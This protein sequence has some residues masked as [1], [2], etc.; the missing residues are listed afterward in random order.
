MAI[1]D[2]PSDYFNTVTYTGTNSDQSITGVNFQ[3]D[4]VWIKS[5]NTTYSHRLVDVV[6]GRTEV[7]FSNNTDATQTDSYGTIGSFDSD[8]VSFVQGT[9]NPSYA[10]TND[11]YNYVMWN[12]L[13]NGTPSSNT[14][15]SITSSV[16]ANTT[17][18]FSII[19]YTGT[20]SVATIGHG[21]GAVPKM[22]ITR[23][24]ST[25]GQWYTYHAS[26]G[27]THY[28]DL[29]STAAAGDDAEMWNDTSPT[30]SVFTVGV[31]GN[32]NGSGK[33][34]IA[35]AFAEKTGYSK[36]GS[37]TGNGNAD[38]T[39]VYTGFKPAFVIVKCTSTTGNNWVMIDNK[40]LGYNVDNN[41]LYCDSD[42]TEST[43]DVVDL[44][45]NGFKHRFTGGTSNGS[46][47]SYI[48]MAFAENP[49][50][51]SNFNAATAR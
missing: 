31:N 4:F 48:Y 28:L 26:L 11:N 41:R 43:V 5:R 30:S 2:K 32:T 50:V 12:W 15:G 9:S 16:S 6:R 27:N 13:A 49:F 51:A 36:F 1:I 14:D 47:I 23:P 10:G 38:G 20:G 25:T 17:A 34:T 35:Y 46:G 37:Y 45:S 24:Y 19:S 18:G 42:T 29:V 22:I 40:R 44:V 8:G 3:P 7:L 21:L 39:F 33:T